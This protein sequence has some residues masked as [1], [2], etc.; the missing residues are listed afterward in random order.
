MMRTVW[1]L[2]LSVV[3]ASAQDFDPAPFGTAQLHGLITDARLDEISGL[4]ASRRVDDLYWV[5]NDAPRPAELVALDGKGQ[6][7]GSVR[8][9][10]VRAID[11]EDIASY[12]LDGKP[13]LLV[14][15]VGDNLGVRNDYE[16]IAI[17]EPVL[18]ADS[19]TVTVKPAWR[20]RF[21]YPDGPHDVEALAIDV[22]SRMVLLLSKR[23]PRPT[24]YSLP[25]GAGTSG[26]AVAQKLVEVDAIPAPTRE[27]RAAHFPAA[28]YGGSPTAMDIDPSA[29]R[30]IVLT[31]RD[32]WIFAR[33]DGDSWAQAFTRKPQ[34]L[35]LP[36]LAQ[37]EA[38]GFDRAGKAIHVS[39]E[40]L[41][42][43]WLRFEDNRSVH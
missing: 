10:G 24:L 11:W 9:E 28:R 5:H 17:E 25:L 32:I 31:Y 3:G 18:P 4:A 12:S 39:G 36:P 26:M 38:V 40:R 43:P 20:M 21:R 41:P 33:A 23:T 2:A 42:A 16:L 37:A 6:R 29:Q 19:G 13:W 35:P 14:G 15:D 27:E 8:I 30:A 22:P 34:R 7:R 1:L